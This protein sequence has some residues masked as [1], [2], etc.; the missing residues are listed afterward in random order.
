[1]KKFLPYKVATS[2]HI[3]KRWKNKIIAGLFDTIV[4][5]LYNIKQKHYCGR[6][7]QR[8]FVTGI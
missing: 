1:M 3:T 8:A 2:Y 6:Y 5:I 7:V 4:Y